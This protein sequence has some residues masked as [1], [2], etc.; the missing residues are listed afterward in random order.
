MKVYT[1]FVLSVLLFVG[2]APNALA[3][4]SSSTILQE[5]LTHQTLLSARTRMNGPYPP[6]PG[7]GRRDFMDTTHSAETNF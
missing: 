7:N 2:L 3:T 4:N 5:T 6:E 1:Y